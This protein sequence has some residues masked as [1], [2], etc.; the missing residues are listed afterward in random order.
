M[1][2][3]FLG[4]G[5]LAIQAL[6]PVLTCRILR[7]PPATCLLPPQLSRRLWMS[8]AWM[9]WEILC[10][11]KES[12]PWKNQWTWNSVLVLLIFDVFLWHRHDPFTSD[13]NLP[14]H[15]Y[16][17]L[18]I[19]HHLFEQYI[20][21]SLFTYFTIVILRSISTEGLWTVI[22]SSRSRANHTNIYSQSYTSMNEQAQIK[23]RWPNDRI[24]R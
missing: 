18:P 7:A 3:L 15:L 24:C 19:L 21:K 13:Y 5:T 9:T 11:G 22:Q 14:T 17:S 23:W 10:K 8:T 4:P 6:Q 16:Q 2:H 20:C 12:W 1:M